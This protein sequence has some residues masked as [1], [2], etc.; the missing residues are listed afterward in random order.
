MAGEQRIQLV[1]AIAVARGS[2]EPSNLDIFWVDENITGAWYEK[3]KAFNSG[4]NSWELVNRTPEEILEAIKTVDGAGSGLDADTLQG[5]TPAQ[6]SV[7]ALSTGQVLVGQADTIG[8]AQSVGGIATIQ[9]DGTLVYVNGSISHTGLSNIGTNTHAQI[10]AHISDN[11]NPH[12]VTASQVGNTVAQ[13]NAN[14][15]QGSTLNIGTP[16]AGED[17]FTVTWDNTAG[18]F[19]L[20]E[21][22]SN[23]SNAN[24]SWSG[25]STSQNLEGNELAFTGGLNKF[26]KVELTATDRGLLINRV[27]TAQMNLISSPTTNE[28]VYNT[29]LNGLYRYDGSNWVALSAGYGIVEVVNDGNNGVPVYFADLQSAL[30]TCKTGTNTVTLY[31]NLSLTA[32]INIKHSSSG[33]GFGYNFDSLIIN[34]NGFKITYDN[35]ANDYIFDVSLNQQEFKIVGKGRLDRLNSSGTGSSCLVVLGTGVVELDAT[36]YNDSGNAANVQVSQT[37]DYSSYICNFNNSNFI[38]NPQTTTAA[39]LELRNGNF[40]KFNVIS[41]NGNRALTLRNTESVSNLTYTNTS[42]GNGLEMV[43]SGQKISK[44][45]G[46]TNAGKNLVNTNLDNVFDD[47]TLSGSGGISSLISSTKG[48]FS[49]GTINASGTSYTSLIINPTKLDNLTFINTSTGY[50]YIAN[51]TAISNQVL[52][53]CF[54]TSIGDY[55]TRIEIVSAGE[56]AI[57]DNCIFENKK[58]SAADGS[59]WIDDSAGGIELLKCTFS[60]VDASANNLYASTSETVTLANS[61]LSGATTPINANVTITATTDLGNGNTQI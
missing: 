25:G 20:A 61:V 5:Y 60:V 36:F 35:S 47:F 45:T 34:T 48:S 1:N 41:Q 11:S 38:G 50:V 18:E 57:F 42:T 52:K 53:N 55:S 17:T 54:F 51:N 39:A 2:Q 15:L 9:A 27:T 14:Q 16:G 26:E 44:F 12:G 21:G 4:N 30:E 37:S 43:G 3:L 23:I 59:V 46:T 29:D 10:D 6:F 7:P 28:I 32:E 49:N 19:V 22:G 13:W 31:S 33:I 58:A 40:K 8:T 24:L 56:K